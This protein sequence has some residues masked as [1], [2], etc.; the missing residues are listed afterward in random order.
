MGESSEVVEA[1]TARS[2]NAAVRRIRVLVVLDLVVLDF[3]V[4]F[5]GDLTSANRNTF[6]CETIRLVG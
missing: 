4:D 3:V 6:G 1:A 2:A 5:M